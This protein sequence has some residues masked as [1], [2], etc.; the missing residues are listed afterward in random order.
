MVS[1]TERQLSQNVPVA[2]D[3]YTIKRTYFADTITAILCI[4]ANVDYAQ[5]RIKLFGA[6]RQ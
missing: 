4:V 2:Q 5:G 1:L 3:F 6:T